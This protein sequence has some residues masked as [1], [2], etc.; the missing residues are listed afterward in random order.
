[1]RKVFLGLGSNVG[2]RKQNI[3]SA[4][5]EIA[6]IISDMQISNIY[7]SDALLPENAPDGWNMEFYN[8]VCCGYAS[9]EPFELLDKLQYIESKYRD[10]KHERWS[11]R[12]L[13]IDI[14]LMEDVELTT[15]KLQIPHLEIHKRSFVLYPLADLCK[16]YRIYCND[17]DNS[18]NTEKTDIEIII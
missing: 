1:M 6:S 11:P 14:L 8:I 3:I 13:D 7:R 18:L 9:L 16:E 17:V 5:I 12:E 10:P 2:N 4:C 15:D